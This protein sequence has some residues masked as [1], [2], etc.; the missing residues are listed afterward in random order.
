MKLTWDMSLSPFELK[1]FSTVINTFAM[2]TKNKLN[3][4]HNSQVAIKV[5]EMT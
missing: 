4:L 1:T 3:T 2:L 5:E